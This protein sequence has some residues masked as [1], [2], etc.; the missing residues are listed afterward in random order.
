VRRKALL[1]MPPTIIERL[2]HRAGR[3]GQ[4]HY[5]IWPAAIAHNN[6]TAGAVITSD[7]HI[8][9]PSSSSAFENHKLF[10]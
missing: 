5:G 1:E 4:A 6:I 7:L 3:S 10:D 8:I 9:S 2:S